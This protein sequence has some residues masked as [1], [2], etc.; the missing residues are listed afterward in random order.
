MKHSLRNLIIIFIIFVAGLFTAFPRP[1]PIKFSFRGINVNRVLNLPGISFNL[2]GFS[3]NRDLNLKLG[4]DLAGGSHLAFEA[5][6]SKINPDDQQSALEAAKSTIERRVNIF[7][8]SESVVQTARVGESQRIIIELP[9]VRDTRGAVALIGRT[10]QLDFREVVESKEA[11]DEAVFLTLQNTRS[12]GF[13]G[14][15]FRRARPSFDSTSGKPTVSFETK[16]ESS[17]KFAEITTRLVGKPLA[18]FLDG[19]PISAPTIQTPITGGEGQIT[20][21]FT[22]DQ[23]RE[24]AGL[25]NSGALPI[26]VKLIEQRTVQAS[27]GE[28]AVNA[29]VVAGLVGLSMVVLFMVIYYRWLGFLAVVGLLIYGLI[30]LSIYKL[31]PVVLTLPG[32]AG[33]IL[34]VGMA[35]D[36]NILIFERMKEEL[37]VGK[38]WSDSMESAFGRAWDAIRDANTATLLTVFILLNPLNL[39]FLHTS[40]PVRGFAVTLG[41]GILISLFTGIFVTR[42][43]MRVFARQ[44]TEHKA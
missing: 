25:L 32:I 28:T 3:F 24:L 40:G 11:T 41:L 19:L 36:S 10:A 35:V 21:S 2:A 34:S 38:R 31:M 12:T 27:L 8:V 37:R 43:L 44:N 15:D 6:V 33:F 26:P 23:T 7:G 5:D 42:T 9:G 14:A 4:L 1:T 39:S 20:G 16:P 22:S 29:S 18:I 13:T 17:Q 30:T